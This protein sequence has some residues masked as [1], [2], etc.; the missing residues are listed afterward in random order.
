VCGMS[1]V[2]RQYDELKRFNITE[3]CKPPAAEE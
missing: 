3:I 2:D 1:V